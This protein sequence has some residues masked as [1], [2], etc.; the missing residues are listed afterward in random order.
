MDSKVGIKQLK[1]LGLK[2][3]PGIKTGSKA[4]VKT[5]IKSTRTEKE[6]SDSL[7]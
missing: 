2:K 6:R 3:T 4:Y 1:S 5:A 7:E